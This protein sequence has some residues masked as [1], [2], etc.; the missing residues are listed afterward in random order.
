VADSRHESRHH[1]AGVRRGNAKR[2]TASL[3]LSLSLLSP[4]I[5][6]S[7]RSPLSPFLFPCIYLYL[8]LSYRVSLPPL[9]N[10]LSSSASP[11]LFSLP[12]SLSAKGGGRGDETDP[13]RISGT[14]EAH[15]GRM[16]NAALSRRRWRGCH[17][18]RN[19]FFS[20]PPAALGTLERDRVRSAIRGET[21]DK[22][23]AELPRASSTTRMA[24]HLLADSAATEAASERIR[25]QDVTAARSRCA[26]GV[27]P[28]T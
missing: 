11:Y 13:T 4:C 7:N 16:S 5:C 17:Q 27:P 19:R 15:R 1:P 12:L 8:P 2:Q 26:I 20:L 9:S 22:R 3:P 18:R 24:R 23:L 14:I 21:R 6:L 25:E 28:P 10:S